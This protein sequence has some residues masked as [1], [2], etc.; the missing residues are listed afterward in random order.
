M[1]HVNFAKRLLA[2][3]CCV[4]INLHLLLKDICDVSVHL[5]TE[6]QL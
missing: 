6:L 1:S 2:E 5:W 3:K 4:D